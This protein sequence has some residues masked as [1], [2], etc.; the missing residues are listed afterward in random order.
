MS[1][2]INFSSIFHSW[3]FSQFLKMRKVAWPKIAPLAGPTENWNCKSWEKA[4]NESEMMGCW[5]EWY[6]NWHKQYFITYSWKLWF[7]CAKWCQNYKLRIK[8]KSRFLIIL[9]I[10]L[11]ASKYPI[12][13]SGRTLVVP[14]LQ[15]TFKWNVIDITL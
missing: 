3:N 12:L 10:R 9:A 4:P 14:N 11:L 6:Q 5:A 1:I 7:Y 15:W 8:K 13:L 2:A